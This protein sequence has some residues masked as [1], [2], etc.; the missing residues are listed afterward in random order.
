MKG[1]SRAGNSLEGVV[2]D[3]PIRTNGRRIGDRARLDGLL[4]LRAGSNGHLEWG[5]G[6][7][8]GRRCSGEGHGGVRHVRCAQFTLN[9]GALD[10]LDVLSDPADGGIDVERADVVRWLSSPPLLYF[11]GAAWYTFRRHRCIVYGKIP[12]TLTGHTYVPLRGHWRCIRPDNA[13]NIAEEYAS[14]TA[15]R[16]RYMCP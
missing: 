8:N 3:L 16:G 2:D 13:C 15:G 6:R 11:S 9:N 12:L 4:W 10:L 1:R 5:A 7:D 14:A